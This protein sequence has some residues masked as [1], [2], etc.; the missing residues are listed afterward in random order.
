[1]LIIKRAPIFPTPAPAPVVRPSTIRTIK[2]ATTGGKEVL[3]GS[4]VPQVVEA[5]RP[6][7]GEAWNA[8]ETQ[9]ASDGQIRPA[10]ARWVKTVQSWPGFVAIVALPIL[11]RVIEESGETYAE[12]WLEDKDYAYWTR[13]LDTRE[14]G[15]A[16][17]LD[18]VTDVQMDLSYLADAPF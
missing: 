13:P 9:Q 2:R 11:Q 3:S 1:M 7:T 12:A 5:G 16:D 8:R 18:A 17:D 10:I 6:D 15:L 4:L 14:G